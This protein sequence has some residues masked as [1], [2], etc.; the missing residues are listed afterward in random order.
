VVVVQGYTGSGKSSQIPQV[1]L[2]NPA[3]WFPGPGGAGKV[4]CTQPR[5]LAVAAVATRVAQERGSALGGEVGYR[6]GQQS[7]ATAA[8][9]LLFA[10]AGIALEMLR[11]EGPA[12]TRPGLSFSRHPVYFISDS[13]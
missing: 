4:L 10:T 11:A 6:I 3:P 1:L 13:L 12:W 8:T 5:R 7:V 2:D 9:R